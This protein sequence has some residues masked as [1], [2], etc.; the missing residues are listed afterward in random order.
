VSPSYVELALQKQRLQLKSA[1]QREALVAAAAG[2]VPV[3]TLFD[4]VR[5]GTRWLARHPEWLAGG[6]V[7]L[8]V[9]RPRVVLRWL[10]RGFLAWQM[11]RKVEGWRRE[12]TSSSPFA[13][14]AR[15]R[16]F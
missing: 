13:A 16:K 10:E 15:F 14:L 4:T 6:I 5:E 11:W 2:L 1:A 7:A 9:A 3:L 8:A 12:R